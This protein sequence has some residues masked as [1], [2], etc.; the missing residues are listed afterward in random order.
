MLRRLLVSMMILAAFATFFAP[1]FAVE[2]PTDEQGR[3][4][5]NGIS[6][7]SSKDDVISQLDNIGIDS[8]LVVEEDN[9]KVIR[10]TNKAGTRI[11][12]EFDENDE[13]WDPVLSRVI[14]VMSH[15]VTNGSIDNSKTNYDKFT[16]TLEWMSDIYGTPDFVR[17]VSGSD[18]YIT[19][20]A[21]LI[22]KDEALISRMIGDKGAY[23][24]ITWRNVTLGYYQNIADGFSHDLWYQ[25]QIVYSDQPTDFDEISKEYDILVPSS[26]E[27]TNYLLNPVKVPIGE[28]I[29][30]IHI[31][32]GEYQV[33]CNKDDRSMG[34]EVYRVLDNG[35]EN[36]E[37]IETLYSKSDDTIGRLVLLDGDKVRIRTGV[38]IFSPFK[39]LGFWRIHTTDGE[40]ID[41][42]PADQ[43]WV[44]SE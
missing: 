40:T 20:D 22:L 38:A 41:I 10:Y 1:A 32:V 16:V 30:G 25:T 17:I 37:I 18:R 3:Y 24:I 35:F 11:K 29:V 33:S 13:S 28:Y 4:L 42:L 12:F 27:K 15:P 39:G 5:Y 31:P 2:E 44:Q 23:L 9:E 14:T 34:I 26:P 36:L 6:L 8:A 21:D 7:G 43:M 19:Q